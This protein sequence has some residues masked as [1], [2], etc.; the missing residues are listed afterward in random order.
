MKDRTGTTS[1]TGIPGAIAS[2]TGPR[3][4]LLTLGYAGWAPG[5]LEA[6]IKAKAW[7]AVSAGEALLF[8]GNYEKKWNRTMV[9][10]AINL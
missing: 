5:Q 8:E 2:G 6:E 4:S 7:A 9:R 10:R 3:R 1:K